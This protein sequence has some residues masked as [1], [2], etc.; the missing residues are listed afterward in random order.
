MIIRKL[1]S[2]DDLSELILLSKQFFL[3]YEDH[4]ETF[5]IESLG[6][7][8]IK[9]FF[10]N[11]L[12]NKNSNILIAVEN[13]KIIAYISFNIKIRFGFFRVKRIGEISGL[14]VHKE[15]RRK[16]IAKQLLEKAIEWFKSN[17]LNYYVL[18]TSS[19]NEG[20]IEFY[21]S[22]GLKPLRTQ[23]IGKIKP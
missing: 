21:T 18:E 17:S 6:D 7:N 2:D 1:T 23:L 10:V 8:P 11:S 9:R 12:G 13:N 3:E 15:Y 16:G 19:K 22:L 20:A 5:K 4:N 14:M